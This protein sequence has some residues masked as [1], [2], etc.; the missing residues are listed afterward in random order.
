MSTPST[1]A[2]SASA[3]L[4]LAAWFA[5]A[6]VLFFLATQP[7]TLE[8]QLILGFGTLWFIIEV[9]M[10]ARNPKRAAWI[11]V[12]RLLV[13]LAAIFLSL[14]Y[15]WWRITETIP[16]DYGILD[17]L[18]G[19][20]LLAA[21]LIGL[22]TTLFGHF[23][24][25]H[26]L[27]R[28]PPPLPED[29][30]ALPTVDILVPTYNEDISILEVTIIAAT[31][32]RYPADRFNV[33]LIDDG[34]T[35]QKRNDKDPVKAAAA[36][37]RH[38]DLQALCQRY[39]AHY[40][41]R[42]RNEH[43][44]AGNVNNAL[45]HIHG[46]LV[47]ILDC[48]HIPT[49]DILENTVGF[50]I[51]NPKLFLL[52]TPHN[53][54][55]PDPVERNL[56]TFQEMPAEN[57]LF[58]GV[59][60]PGLDFWNTSFFCGSA[61]VLRRSVLD[62]LGGI[63]GQTITEDAETTLDALGLGYE[64]AY[65][66]KP[67]VSG[68]QPETYSG[69][70]I[71]RVRW[72]QGM[73]QIFM[74]KNAWQV[75]GLKFVQRLLYTNF[76]LY[77]LFPFARIIFVL[78]PL[79]F[80]F[81]GLKIFD[82]PPEEMLAYAAPHLLAGVIVTQFFYGHVRWPF[83]SDLYETTQS[84]YLAKGIIE[85]LRRPRAPTFQ[86]TPKGEHLEQDFISSLAT[87]FYVLIAIN[88]VALLGGLVRFLTMPEER[89]AILMVS[90]WALF[91]LILLSGAI[92]VLME[93]KQR[94]NAPRINLITPVDVI[95]HAGEVALQGRAFDAS[96]HGLGITLP[97]EARHDLM[98]GDHIYLEL[99]GHARHLRAEVRF[100]GP[101]DGMLQAGLI[102]RPETV[103]EQRIAIALAFG[104]SERLKQNL[105]HRHRG[106][107]VF[108]ALGYLAGKG[109]LHTLRH[110]VFKLKQ[111]LRGRRRPLVGKTDP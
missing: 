30:A 101:Q 54:V 82:A 60:Q 27:C 62:E 32:I 5:L 98:M 18:A 92:G 14:R 61:A 84:L 13:I 7:S 107:G 90:L 95:L 49:E 110:V 50:F 80:L 28:K 10:T 36:Q 8:F 42:A 51:Q 48:D 33:Y 108:S 39:G 73:L 59:I 89:G 24:N 41:T 93:R 46:D 1:T 23:I 91:D 9:L 45:Q 19:L 31:Q 104:D 56:D 35:E 11:P 99:P 17:L 78:M 81:F 100:L 96:A 111:I 75:K 47:L 29:P 12:L 34:G 38:V 83:I 74:L 77:W 37:A 15:F 20:L 40:I 4:E 106:R 25:A 52:Q 79:L 105:H 67:M 3:L 2:P 58:Y 65:L 103:E 68:L 102:Y 71:Q 76:A 66:P 55:T 86:V 16:F 21:E 88:A 44:K 64:T 63:G 53:F 94:R 97:K 69:F 26:P 43:A 72:A 87:P 22:V 57:E 70:I 109:F 6:S 85:V